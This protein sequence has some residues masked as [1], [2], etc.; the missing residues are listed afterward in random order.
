MLEVELKT[1]KIPQSNEDLALVSKAL[2]RANANIQK[3]ENETA[4]ML[5][6]KQT[7]KEM[8]AA[9]KAKDLAV[10]EASDQIKIL[11]RDYKQLQAEYSNLS[12]NTNQSY[13]QQYTEF[14]RQIEEQKSRF[15]ELTRDRDALVRRITEMEKELIEKTNIAD[16]RAG[17]I[18]T[19]T[20]D[21]ET[22]RVQIATDGAECQK[23]NDQLKRQVNFLTEKMTR[24]IGERDS[25]DKRLEERDNLIRNTPKPNDGK[26][27][28]LEQTIDTLQRENKRLSDQNKAAQDEIT[29]LKN[30]N[31][32]LLEKMNRIRNLQNAR[33]RNLSGSDDEAEEI[34]PSTSSQNDD[35]AMDIIINDENSNTEPAQAESKET[36][37][38][39]S[40]SNTPKP[41]RK[42]KRLPVYDSLNTP[43]VNQ[44]KRQN[45]GVNAQDEPSYDLAS[46]TNMMKN[47]IESGDPNIPN[48]VNTGENDPFDSNTP[49]FFH[50]P[51]PP[52]P[53]SNIPQTKYSFDGIFQNMIEAIN[54]DSSTF[55]MIQL[56]A[57]GI[58]LGINY[59]RF[60]R[61]EKELLM[62]LHKLNMVEA[63]AFGRFSLSPPISPHIITRLYAPLKFFPNIS[64]YECVVSFTPP[65]ELSIHE[66]VSTK[67]T[68]L[69]LRISKT[70]IPAAN[71]EMHSVSLNAI[72]P[73]DSENNT[74]INDMVI[75]VTL[76]KYKNNF[77]FI[78]K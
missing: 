56:I 60:T 62:R 74:S 16:E 6:L 33:N 37:D 2:E 54:F 32:T 29:K 10:N 61:S 23:V 26:I 15:K 48:S 5:N 21:I 1:A 30:L 18:I 78:F 47:A 40:T 25:L 27:I 35:S 76:A 13:N 28:A 12:V 73:V 63:M 75:Q 59:N 77:D 51:L 45:L 66:P 53:N 72:D 14:N 57:F 65:K 71:N 39:A 8:G 67:H 68:R 55:N 46:W 17:K 3:L 42:R 52:L 41:K 50:N 22:L 31:N 49:F 58:N 43:T 19:L 20:N 44:T 69:P 38:E 34:I 9:L 70:G 7:V 36:P 24:V 64:I 11:T 4:E